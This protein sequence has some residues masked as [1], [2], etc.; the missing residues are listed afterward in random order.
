MNAADEAWEIAGEAGRKTVIEALRDKMRRRLERGDS[1][2]NLMAL[3]I[4]GLSGI[5]QI[6]ATRALP[7]K[8]A[9]MEEIALAYVRG[10]MRGGDGPVNTD[11]SPFD[12]GTYNNDGG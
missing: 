7:E 11:G 9:L 5:A 4:G 8:A 10:A 6:M 12:S 3:L 2:K 1:E